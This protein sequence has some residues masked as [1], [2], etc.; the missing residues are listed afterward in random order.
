MVNRVELE[1]L[2]RW[3]LKRVREA[4]LR[5]FTTDATNS[6]YSIVKEHGIKG[7]YLHEVQKYDFS[8]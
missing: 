2:K 1:N 7:L 6:L 4:G 5:Y 8:V 3:Y